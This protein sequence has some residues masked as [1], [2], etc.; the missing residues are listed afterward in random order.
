MPSSGDG[1]AEGARRL[2]RRAVMR[3]GAVAAIGGVALGRAAFAE[4]SPSR[5]AAPRG[6]RAP[7]APRPNATQ[8]TLAV[9]PT[10]L[11]PD[12][13]AAMQGIAVNGSFP[14]P[15]IRARQGEQLRILVENRLAGGPT[16]IHWHGLLVPAGMD[17]V[18]DISNAPIAAGETY[19]YEFPVLQTGTYWYHSHVGFQEQ[20]GLFGPLVI[21]AADEPVRSDHD[22]TVLLSDWLHRSPE[23]AYAAL[24]GKGGGAQDGGMA[25]MDSAATATAAP[26][27]GAP[28][29]VETAMPAMPAGGGADL[30]DIQ[31][32]TFLLNGA[33]PAQP[34]TYAARPGERIRLRIVN[35]GSSTYFNVLLDGHALEVTHADGLAVEPVTVDHLLMGMAES[36]DVIVTLRGRGS[37][38]LHALAQDGSGQALGVLHTPDVAPRLDRTI[39]HLD[40]RALSYAQL[41]ALAPT[42]LPAGPTRTFRLP[43]QGDMQRYVWMIDGQAWPQADPLR[44]R[45]GEQVQLELV[46]QTMMWHPMHLHGHFFRVLQGAGDRCPLKHT[47]NV[48]PGET[49]RI[50]FAAD[51]PGR[52]F[53][54]CH[55]LYH[56]E[57]GMARELVYTS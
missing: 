19:V 38:T 45:Q 10:T 52:W 29:A 25:G 55:N 8:Y 23:E 48:A 12:G 41:R 51:N 27:G 6:R 13:E 49:V 56:L 47:V 7:Y 44:I 3:G 24:R 37:Y 26:T 20:V 43:L 30:S 40:G 57:A 5:G 39:P 46:N 54:H 35:A 9:G 28:R 53:F 34:W 14:G 11:D 15:E 33:A 31:Y 4:Q 32:P 50:E 17:G 18:P 1:E 36:Y 42:T 16:A 22:V 21:E 2:S